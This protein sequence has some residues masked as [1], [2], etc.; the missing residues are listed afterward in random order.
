MGSNRIN[1]AF[2]TGANLLVQTIQQDLGIPINH[3]VEVNFDTFRDISNAVG[4]VNF[5]F[6]TP[7]KDTY[8]LSTS[9]PP[10]ATASKG[11][12]AL[13]FVRS[14]HYEYYQN[15][16]WHFEAAERPGPHPAPAGL[17]QEDDQEG[18]GRV[19]QSDRPQRHDR[20]DHQEPHRRQPASA[21]A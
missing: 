9:R 10:G 5:Y 14:R 7:A 13:A 18:R 19:H 15:G 21:P 11:D 20:R 8:S 4:G 3:Y 2:D 12:Q 1:T 6:P 16:Y 17:H